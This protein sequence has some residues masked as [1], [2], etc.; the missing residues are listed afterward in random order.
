MRKPCLHP[1]WSAAEDGITLRCVAC[2]EPYVYPQNAAVAAAA[3]LRF[4]LEQVAALLAP[5]KLRPAITL[6]ASAPR[7]MLDALAEYKGAVRR[8]TVWDENEY[9]QTPFAI[10]SV[11][12]SIDGVMFSALRTEPATADEIAALRQ[13]EPEHVERRRVNVAVRT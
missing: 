7:E 12:I 4:R 13:S 11:D 8:R 2:K 10:V 5:L 6:S 1:A 3:M 9:N